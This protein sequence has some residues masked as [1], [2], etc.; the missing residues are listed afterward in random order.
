MLLNVLQTLQSFSRR[1]CDRRNHL[2]FRAVFEGKEAR[3]LKG[4]SWEDYFM[5]RIDVVRVHR[6]GP[7][8]VVSRM[9]VGSH[10]KK[11]LE[12]FGG[13]IPRKWQ[14]LRRKECI[15]LRDLGSNISP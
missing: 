9:P 15:A 10:T 1:R 11:G 2:L 14:E 13:E 6:R 5:N 8:P 7:V 12:L 3:C 4:E